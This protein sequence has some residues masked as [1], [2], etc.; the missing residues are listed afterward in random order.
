MA[1]KRWMPTTGDLAVDRPL[2][3]RAAYA[4][5]EALEGFTDALW[6]VLCAATAGVQTLSGK[7]AH[8][9]VALPDNRART[10]FAR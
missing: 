7:E 1:E 8:A 9:T 3:W 4:S 10:R 2:H 5:R 6:L